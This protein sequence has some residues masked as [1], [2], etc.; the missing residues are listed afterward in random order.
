VVN[1]DLGSLAVLSVHSMCRHQGENAV[2]LPVQL[3]QM[4]RMGQVGGAN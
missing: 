1:E 4:R 3:L 2:P